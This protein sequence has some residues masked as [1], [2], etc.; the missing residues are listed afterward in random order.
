MSDCFSTLL[1]FTFEIEITLTSAHRHGPLSP[2]PLYTERIGE[3]LRDYNR[4][5]ISAKFIFV[6][7]G[8]SSGGGD[9]DGGAG[10]VTLFLRLYCCSETFLF[11]IMIFDGLYTN[12]RYSSLLGLQS[13]YIVANAMRKNDHFDPI[14]VDEIHGEFIATTGQTVDVYENKQ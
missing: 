10:M 7:G 9:D 4:A 14:V 11:H 8:G 13:T 6:G 5:K 2:S 12:R 1:L 3:T